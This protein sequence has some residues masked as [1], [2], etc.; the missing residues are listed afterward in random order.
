MKKIEELTIE[1]LCQRMDALNFM[2]GNRQGLNGI[3]KPLA[4]KPK[5]AAFFTGYEK[6]S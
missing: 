3:K 2:P 4:I 1:E 6:A 5:N